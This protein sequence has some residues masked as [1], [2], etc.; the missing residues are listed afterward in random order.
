MTP[1]STAPSR[2]IF[3]AFCR[4][5]DRVAG[6]TCRYA[7]V[8]VLT[9]ATPPP[10]R[11]L[12]LLR[13]CP[14]SMVV[15]AHCARR[16]AGETPQPVAGGRIASLGAHEGFVPLFE[17]APHRAGFPWPRASARVRDCQGKPAHQPC[18]WHPGTA[19]YAADRIPERTTTARDDFAHR[20]TSAAAHNPT[21]PRSACPATEH[22][23]V[24]APHPATGYCRHHCRE[25]CG[26]RAPAR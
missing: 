5:A 18:S 7:Q 22:R 3:A 26:M 19:S 6:W 14:A 12:L 11:A 24:A 16:N 4:G 21:R 10:R 2:S 1:P 20:Q 23:C 9:P 15:C 25:A 13:K 8:R 17:H